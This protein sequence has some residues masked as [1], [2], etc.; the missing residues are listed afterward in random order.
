MNH[1]CLNE[2]SKKRFLQCWVFYGKILTIREGLKKTRKKCGVFFF[3]K[4]DTKYTNRIPE[5]RSPGVLG[6][7]ES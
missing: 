7:S 4:M 1:T 6:V 2:I 5:S 3:R